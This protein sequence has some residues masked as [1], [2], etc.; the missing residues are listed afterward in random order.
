LEAA[1]AG[2]PTI[3]YA[4]GGALETIVPDETGTFFPE[5]TA[6]A[7]AAAIRTFDPTRYDPARLRA[8]AEEYRPERFIARLR[9]IVDETLTSRAGS[10]Q[11]SVPETGARSAS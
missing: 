8:H 10:P 6:N 5:P 11:P 3:A 7:L 9:A 4:A 2:R 1:A